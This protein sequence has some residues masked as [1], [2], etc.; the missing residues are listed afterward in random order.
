[1]NIAKLE[2]EPNACPLTE[3]LAMNGFV[4][5]DLAVDVNVRVS[6]ILDIAVVC[7]S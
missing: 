2:I 1:M 5:S 7:F 4:T 6:F 3:P